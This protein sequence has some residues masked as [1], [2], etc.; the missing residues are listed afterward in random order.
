MLSWLQR[1]MGPTPKMK[2]KISLKLELKGQIFFLL[3][4][5]Q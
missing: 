2:V 5:K 3:K 1:K 4:M